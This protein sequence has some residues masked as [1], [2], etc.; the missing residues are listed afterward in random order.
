MGILR[1]LKFGVGP[2]VGF[3]TKVRDSLHP[4]CW[5]FFDEE[6]ND[7][8][9]GAPTFLETPTLNVLQ[10]WDI[11]DIH[12]WSLGIPR[13]ASSKHAWNWVGSTLDGS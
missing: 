13:F 11:Y 4:D 6:T 1:R 12:I 7:D 3:F 10:P 2:S 9:R 5:S 8:Q